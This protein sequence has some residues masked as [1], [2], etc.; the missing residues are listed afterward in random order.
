MARV[1]R[2]PRHDNDASFVLIH[3]ER[4][5]SASDRSLDLTLVGTEGAAPY[6]FTRKLRVKAV[7]ASSPLSP[8]SCVDQVSVISETEPGIL[9]KSKE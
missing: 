1:I 6:L 8:N 4:L 5:A 9:T 3:V 2:I 7:L